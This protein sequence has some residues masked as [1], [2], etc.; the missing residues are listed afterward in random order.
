LNFAASQW[1]LL[2]QLRRMILEEDLSVI[3]ATDAY[4]S[5]LFG[6]ILKRMTGQPLVVAVFANQDALYEAT[7]ALA[8]PRL[9]PFRFLE[10]WVARQ[11]LSRA[12]LVVAGN[13]NNLD[14]AV[15]NGALG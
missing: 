15:A 8:M 2:R 14:F 7:G 12:D 10:Q 13:R 5:G 3:Y 9:L 1:K 6:L 11:V 4:Y